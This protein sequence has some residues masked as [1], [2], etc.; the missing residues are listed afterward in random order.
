MYSH[1]G[2]EIQWWESI[3]KVYYC[4]LF[5]MRVFLSFFFEF[6][7]SLATAISNTIMPRPRHS[8]LNFLHCEFSM[9]FQAFHLLTRLVSCD[10]CLLFPTIS[11]CHF[12]WNVFR[13]DSSVGPSFRSRA[14]TMFSTSSRASCLL[15]GSTR[16]NCH[17][18]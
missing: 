6:G 2:T 18:V 15:Y 9:T 5:H 14:C 4:T 12:W 7:F 16:P 3:G 13:T 10:D 11:Q 17:C 8:Y 1:H